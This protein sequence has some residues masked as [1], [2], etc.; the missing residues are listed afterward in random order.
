MKTSINYSIV[1]ALVVMAWVSTGQAAE[2][3]SK[4]RGTTIYKTED[5]SGAPVFSDEA[6]EG[7]V[8]VK[9]EEPATYS[10]DGLIQRYN[11]QNRSSSDEQ[12]EISYKRLRITAP[13]NDESIRSN[14]GNVEVSYEISP[15]PA[16]GHTLQLLMDGA[17][18]REIR[19]PG[20]LQ[21][22]NV[23][24]GTHRLQ[25]R[26]VDENDEVVKI[27]PAVTIHLLRHSIRHP[28]GRKSR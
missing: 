8:E 1:T 6:T 25:V 3:D 27:S 23:D 20:P 12:D 26:I 2:G 15:S 19:G 24:R 11:N 5:A 10:S 18:Y 22:A 21:L 17:V 16:D 28:Q 13:G 9:V 4:T 14:P 7:A